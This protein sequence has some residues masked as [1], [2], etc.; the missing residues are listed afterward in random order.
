[1][2]LR[3]VSHNLSQKMNRYIASAFFVLL[4][5]VAIALIGYVLHAGFGNDL[6]PVQAATGVN[7]MIS[8]QAKMTDASGVTVTNGTYQLTIRIYSSASGDTCLYTASGTACGTATST[9]V[10]VTNGLFSIMIGDT[11][12][13]NALTLDFNSDTYYL[14]IQVGNDSEMTPRKRIGAAGYAINSDTLDGY[15]TSLT[16]GSTSFVPVTNSAGDIFLTGR[17]L[18]SSTIYAS[19]ST[20]STFYGALAVGTSTTA[21]P[22]MFSV[23]GSVIFQSNSSVSSTPTSGAGTRMMWIPGKSAF[24]AGITNGYFFASEMPGLSGDYG[25]PDVWD[26]QF[27]GNYSVAMGLGTKASG[28]G[29]FAMGVSST[30]SGSASYAVGNVAVANNMGSVAIGTGVTATGTFATAIGGVYSVASGTESIALGSNAYANGGPSI[31]IGGTWDVFDIFGVGNHQ[32][33]AN[34]NK[35]LAMGYDLEANGAGSFVIGKGYGSGD[36]L[37][38]DIDNSLMVG[39]GSNIPTFFVGPSAG[40]GTTGNVGIGTAGPMNR[41]SVQGGNISVANGTATTTIGA[42]FFSVAFSTSDMLG[43]FYVDSSGNVSASGTQYIYGSTTSTFVGA[44]AVGTSTASIPA[45]L[46]VDGSVLFSGN[47]GAT[48]VSG[49][50]TRLMWIPS[51]GAFRAG[52]V[53]PTVTAGLGAPTAGTEWDDENIGLYSIALG[54]SSKASGLGSTAIGIAN[55]ANGLGSTALGASSTALG[56]AANAFGANSVAGGNYSTAIGYLTTASGAYSTAIGSGTT[57]SG[58]YGATAMGWGSIAEGSYS[59]AMGYF[60]TAGDY[61]T[62]MGFYTTANYNSTAIGR[63]TT[64]IGSESIAIGNYASSTAQNSIVIGSGVTTSGNPLINST[65]NSLAVGFNSTVPTL[66]V[67]GGSGAGT[68]GSVAIATTTANAVAKLS[69]DGSVLFS[70]NSGATPVSGAGTRMMWIPSKAAFRAGAVNPNIIGT[71]TEWDDNNIGSYSIALGLST[72]ASGLYSFATGVSTTASAD[73]STAMGYNTIASFEYSTAMGSETTAS[74]GYSTAMGKNTIASGSV[75][76]AI[77]YETTASGDYSTAM[78]ANTTASS[79]KSTAMGDRTTASGYYSFALGR[80]ASS[81]ADS[82]FTIG[83]GSAISTPLVNSTANSLAV[84]FAST[85]A[86]LLVENGRITASGTLAVKYTGTSTF[87]GNLAVGGILTQNCTGNCVD[88]AETFVSSELVEP[89]DL[90]MIDTATSTLL[91]S[92]GLLADSHGYD[93]VVKKTN[94]GYSD[95]IVGVVSTNPAITMNGDTTVLGTSGVTETMNPPVA[96]AGRVPVKVTDE[97]GP[98][99]PG[100]LLVSSSSTPGAAMRFNADL[101]GLNA[102]LRGRSPSIIGMVLTGFDPANNQNGLEPDKNKEV[103]CEW[104]PRESEGTPALAGTP[105]P[106]HL[107]K[108]LVLIKNNY[109]QPS[110][111]SADGLGLS[112]SADGK[113]LSTRDIDMGGNAIL[114]VKS[115]ASASGNWSIDEEGRIVAKKVTA[116]EYEIDARKKTD[117]PTGQAGL[118]PTLG[119]ARI[120]AGINEILVN[121]NRTH[122]NSNI[123]ITFYGNPGG[124]W[125]I[126]NQEDGWF[127]VTLSTGTGSEIDFR[128]WILSVI[129]DENLTSASGLQTSAPT[130]SAPTEVRPLT[131]SLG[132]PLGGASPSTTRPMAESRLWRDELAGRAGGAPQNAVVVDPA[133]RSR[134]LFEPE[135]QS[136]RHGREADAAAEVAP[137]ASPEVVPLA[138]PADAV[139]EVLSSSGSPETDIGG[140]PNSETPSSTPEIMP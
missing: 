80:Y 77:G 120:P 73:Y 41:L 140:N 26:D 58:D 74:G 4:P 25:S 9:P 19:G 67:T 134:A 28:Q 76:T 66:M 12:S 51:K 54:L 135:P 35:S 14:G 55:Y 98:I 138:D 5:L 104:S 3:G 132:P 103:G 94:T 117:L 116:E 130:E 52:L 57:A 82:S 89:G 126:S 113:I 122:K 99:E 24:R 39:F 92:H 95:K 119:R 87:A 18:T 109:I 21:I 100:D 93:V 56:T 65:A 136:R 7:K 46:S 68:Y 47:S 69:V 81:T 112:V 1:M 88:I 13:Q 118:D 110:G 139:A 53:D 62:A 6:K 75:S 133:I 22:A 2:L 17:Y 128:Y 45:K 114:N 121:N 16:G 137:L 40:Y 11:T 111:I 43:K 32:I 125:W 107:G 20:T 60:T 36:R 83:Y 34:G 84:G 129:E 91:D 101:R 102:D 78:G 8:Y 23:D 15:N 72:K 70:G 64:A 97:N 79:F 61:S 105:A 90:V 10:T 50:G 38:N 63:N 124:A 31:A 123:V 59:T 44:L 33:Y 49:A 30:A 37:I 131:A 85:T 48:P 71:G 27:I 42:N 96:L 127:K 29:A 106:C 115:L 86:T 108:V